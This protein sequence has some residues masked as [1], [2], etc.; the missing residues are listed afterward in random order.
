MKK[1]I[2]I[3]AIS[4]MAVNLYAN[5]CN[6]GKCIWL[7]NESIR[8]PTIQPPRHQP[9]ETKNLDKPQYVV[10]EDTKI[11]VQ[12]AFFMGAEIGYGTVSAPITS[13]TNSSTILAE[14]SGGG[15]DFGIVAG[16][17]QLFGSYFG[18]RY[19]GNV[20]VIA[21]KLKP[22]VLRDDIGTGLYG[23]NIMRSATLVN[24][25][26]NIDMLVNFISNNIADFGMFVGASVGGNYWGGKGP[27][28]IN[29]YMHTMMANTLIETAAKDWYA[30]RHFLDVSLNVGLRTNIAKHHDIELALKMSMLKN[31]F[32]D[33]MGNISYLGIHTKVPNYNTTLR[34][35]YSF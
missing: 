7:D 13:R 25:A 34:Y 30:K 3:V 8:K 5:P 35:I 32:V 31:T 22:K 1:F 33:N 9:R 14:T 2:K 11:L 10:A 29:E 18:L 24:Y 4:C 16:Y 20:N 23:G 12:H 27:D 17:K 15:V 26:F 21:V 6:G 19:Y 28:E